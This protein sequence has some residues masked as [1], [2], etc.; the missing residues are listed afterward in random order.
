VEALGGVRRVRSNAPV[1][2]T[3]V[4]NGGAMYRSPRGHTHFRLEFIRAVTLTSREYV[5]RVRRAC[6]SRVSI[7]RSALVPSAATTASAVSW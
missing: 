5:P 3:E 7:P 4:L 6:T 2:L 1:A